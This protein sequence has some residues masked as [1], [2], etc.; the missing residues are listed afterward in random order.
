MAFGDQDYY[1][2]LDPD[3]WPEFMRSGMFS[4]RVFCQSARSARHGQIKLCV[5]RRRASC[6]TIRHAV[7]AVDG[8]VQDG[9]GSTGFDR[10]SPIVEHPA[11]FIGLTEETC[12]G[13]I[14]TPGVHSRPRRCSAPGDPEHRHT[15]PCAD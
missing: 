1:D 13:T 4:R 3:A 10:Q 15:L 8:E 6:V 5:A 2:Y 9:G 12:H 11:M 14:T 7:A